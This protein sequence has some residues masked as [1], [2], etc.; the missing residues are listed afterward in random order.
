VQLGSL[1]AM[2][3]PGNRDIARAKRRSPEHF[4]ERNAAGWIGGNPVFRPEMRP[5]KMLSRFLPPGM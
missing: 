2:V 3:R 5:R 4:Q 1:R